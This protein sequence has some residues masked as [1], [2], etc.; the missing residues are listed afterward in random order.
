MLLG[1]ALALLGAYEGWAG[2]DPSGGPR[3]G[4]T[5][6]A[7]AALGFVGLPRL[8]HATRHGSRSFSI[9]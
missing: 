2:A 6:L 9:T 8:A 1:L 4:P 5:T 7:C 3:I